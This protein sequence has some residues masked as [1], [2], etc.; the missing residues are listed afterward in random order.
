[1][2]S[3][4]SVGPSIS[5]LSWD[6]SGFIAAS[7]V[8]SLETRN[9]ARWV[10]PETKELGNEQM[11]MELQDSSIEPLPR[12]FQIKC[13]IM[14]RELYL[15]YL[16]SHQ[17]KLILITTAYEGLFARNAYNSNR[18]LNEYWVRFMNTGYISY[19]AL[20][21]SKIIGSAAFWTL[22]SFWGR[23]KVQVSILG[24]LTIFFLLLVEMKGNWILSR[25]IKL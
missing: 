16:N 4:L 9:I 21:G 23:L 13:R 8:A 18:N 19:A 3:L 6:S 24:W 17:L 5:A 2:V 15:G 7:T 14:S 25:P 20:I 11:I 10:S 12:H 22:S 1:M